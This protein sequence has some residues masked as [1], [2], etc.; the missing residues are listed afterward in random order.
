MATNTIAKHSLIFQSK[1][2]AAGGIENLRRQLTGLGRTGD[3]TATQFST[4]GSKIRSGLAGIGAVLGVGGGA[5]GAGFAIK[6][7]AEAE[8]TRV[9]FETIIGSASEAKKVLSELKDFSASTPLQLPE[10]QDAAM[11]GGTT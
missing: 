1:N 3:K 9:S 2:L 11:C 10:L 8:T 4:I 7:A 6:L 5:F